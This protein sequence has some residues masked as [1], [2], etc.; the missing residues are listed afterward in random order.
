MTTDYQVKKAER[1]AKLPQWVQRELRR[2]ERDVED[3]KT[4]ATAGP[5]DSNTFIQRFGNDT[6][7]GD[8]PR[9]QFRLGEGWHQSIEVRVEG[10]HVIVHGGSGLLV[11]PR[12]ANSISLRPTR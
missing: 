5:E 2:L 7:L 12:A 8:S 10:D 1:I 9:V 3:W 6:P 11:E 4:Q